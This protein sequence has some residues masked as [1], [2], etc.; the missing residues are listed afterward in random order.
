MAAE[1]LTEQQAFAKDG[2]ILSVVEPERPKGVTRLGW[3]G[4]EHS[5]GGECGYGGGHGIGIKWHLL[6]YQPDKHNGCDN[7]Y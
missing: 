4:N 2:F 3:R 6:S 1:K 7:M 5:V